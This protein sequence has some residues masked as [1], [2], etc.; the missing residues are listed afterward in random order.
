MRSKCQFSI[1]QFF[2]I[3]FVLLASLA[4]FAGHAMAQN[5]AASAS[6][7]CCWID[8][9]TGKSVP[10]VPLGEVNT[11]GL[12]DAG[13]AQ[14]EGLDPHADRAFNPKTGQN[15][16]RVPC[17]PPATAKPPPESPKVSSITPGWS[18]MYFGMGTVKNW[19]HIQ[20]SETLAA[21]GT[22]TNQFTDS[23]DPI[24]GAYQRASTSHRGTTEIRDGA[25]SG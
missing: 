4:L 16:V 20:T 23:G 5:Q 18:G 11:S 24:G 6:G 21:T 8:V 1:S 17:P 9:K 22:L 15:F 19:G 2:V 13:F 14:M 25:G 3:S 7:D 10:S 12:I